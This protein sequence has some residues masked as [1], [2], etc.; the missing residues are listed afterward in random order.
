MAN[1]SVDSM[2]PLGF[3]NVTPF[4]QPTQ[5]TRAKEILHDGCADLPRIHRI[6]HHEKV[7]QMPIPGL[8]I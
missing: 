6:V 8:H 5:A 2:S 1:R 3:L 4:D 7:D